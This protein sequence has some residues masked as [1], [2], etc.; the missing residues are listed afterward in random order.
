MLI[1]VLVQARSTALGTAQYCSSATPDNRQQLDQQQQQKQQQQQQQHDDGHSHQSATPASA[2]GEPTTPVPT[3]AEGT[4]DSGAVSEPLPPAPSYEELLLSE[5]A[6]LS[7][8]SRFHLDA[9]SRNSLNSLLKRFQHSAR[10]RDKARSD[11]INAEV[12][13]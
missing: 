1:R 6:K 9:V 5:R 12:G 4:P 2:A 7:G 11:Y 13:L 3:E 10:V 8:S